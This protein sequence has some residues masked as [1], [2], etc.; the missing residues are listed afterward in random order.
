MPEVPYW[1]ALDGIF[2]MPSFWERT[3]PLKFM[4]LRENNFPPLGRLAKPPELLV[5]KNR[6]SSDESLGATAESH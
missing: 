2:H 3:S 1:M 5:P 4:L 6:H